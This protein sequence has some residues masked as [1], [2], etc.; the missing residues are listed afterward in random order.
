MNYLPS[1]NIWSLLVLVAGIV[2]SIMIVTGRD[3]SS[4]AINY[5]SSLVEGEKISLPENPSW[6]SEFGALSSKLDASQV[7]PFESDSTTDLVSVS[8]MSNY[9]N[10]KQ[11][12]AID[13][14]SKEELVNQTLD[15]IESSGTETLKEASL[16]IVP[17]NGKVSMAEYGERLG[18]ILKV[19][20]PN[21]IRNELDIISEAMR[22][23]GTA[24]EE[25]LNLVI[26]LYDRVG[27]DLL[28]MSVP[29][30]FAKA[31]IDIVNGVRGV[32]LSLT[33]L[34]KVNS[35]PI[36]GLYAI[37]MYQDSGASF[38]QAMQAVITFL[39][40]NNIV[41]KQGTGGYYLLYGI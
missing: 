20:K 5:A 26:S 38:L 21:L 35:D 2:I 14:F 28:K 32:T 12:G 30:T 29:K 31:H 16:I 40:Q 4:T 11:S 3:K 18:L 17:D 9:L 24:K 19:N 22:S 6:Q 39:K 36:L 1:K 23:P 25:E 7:E 8:L 13:S 15:F 37:K 41:Y 27:Q 33:Q 10:L 34:K